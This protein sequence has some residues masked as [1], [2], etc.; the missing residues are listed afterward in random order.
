MSPCSE[1]TFPLIN[2]MAMVLAEVKPKQW[3]SFADERKKDFRQKAKRLLTAERR[4]LTNIERKAGSGET[5]A[6]RA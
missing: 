3:R 6:G 1:I 4:I 2:R 5:G